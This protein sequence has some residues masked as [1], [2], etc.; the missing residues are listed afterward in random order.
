MRKDA[1]RLV[2]GIVTASP[3]FNHLR[4]FTLLLECIQGRIWGNGTR[5]GDAI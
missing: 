1:V 3:D 2:E 5:G 4:W